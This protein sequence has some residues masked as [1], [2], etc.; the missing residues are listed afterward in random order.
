MLVLYFDSN[1]CQISPYPLRSP[2]TLLLQWIVIHRPAWLKVTNISSYA[3][4]NRS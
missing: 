3:I 1:V 2:N 4:K